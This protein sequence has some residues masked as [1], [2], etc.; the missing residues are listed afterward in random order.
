MC[1]RASQNTKFFSDQIH[2]LEFLLRK[3]NKEE[4]LN[5]PQISFVIIKVG[6]FQVVKGTL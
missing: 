3:E 2:K 6:I 5:Y 1:F 4:F